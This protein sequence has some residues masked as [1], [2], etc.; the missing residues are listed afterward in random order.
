MPPLMQN[1]PTV[2][3]VYSHAYPNARKL[4]AAALRRNHRYATPTVGL[5]ALLGLAV[6]SFVCLL[7]I[8]VFKE[9]KYVIV[10]D[11]GSSGTRLHVYRWSV[12]PTKHLPSLEE[13]TGEGRGLHAAAQ[14]SRKMGLPGLV[15][16][17][18]GAYKRTE[19][20]PGIDR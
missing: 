20:E 5:F 13:L 2:L 9:N 12:S 3:P 16:S 19:T 4:G 15:S 17:R 1:H 6:F 14:H 11:G 10:I 7:H 18:G 8:H